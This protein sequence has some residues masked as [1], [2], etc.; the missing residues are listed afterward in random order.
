MDIAVMFGSLALL[1]LFIINLALTRSAKTNCGS[2]QRIDTNSGSVMK[3][4]RAQY[5]FSTKSKFLSET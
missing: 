4:R 3:I 1:I 2:P 5:H